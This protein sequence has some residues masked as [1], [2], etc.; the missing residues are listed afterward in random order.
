[1]PEHAIR[2]L[3]HCLAAFGGG[4][5]ASVLR[6]LAAAG[7]LAEVL[8][9][10]AQGTESENVTDS[11]SSVSRM[12]DEEDTVEELEHQYSNNALM[13]G[14]EYLSDQLLECFLRAGE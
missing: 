4:A 2:R 11:T 7:H 5:P 14:L 6:E 13:Q 9:R 10:T 12:A 1:M 8:L 3:A